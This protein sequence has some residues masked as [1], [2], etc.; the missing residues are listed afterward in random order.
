MGLC[1]KF[2]TDIKVMECE[3]NKKIVYLWS[4]YGEETVVKIILKELDNEGTI[5][6][7]KLTKKV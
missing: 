4:P 5:I 1:A 6:E 3:V 7:V 2:T